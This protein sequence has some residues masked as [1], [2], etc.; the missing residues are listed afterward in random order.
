[1]A[2]LAPWSQEVDP[3]NVVQVVVKSQLGSYIE[4]TR[5]TTGCHPVRK[6]NSQGPTGSTFTL[7][8]TRAPVR[9]GSPRPIKQHVWQVLWEADRNYCVS[10]RELRQ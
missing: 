3:T 10:Y 8:R 9:S 1:M 7:D 4:F 6:V 5:F 2:V